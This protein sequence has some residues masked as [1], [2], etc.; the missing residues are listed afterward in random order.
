MQ[1]DRGYLSPYFI[2]NQQNMT[3]ELESPMILLH[4]KKISNVRD[5]LPISKGVA[6]SGRSLLLVSETS[7]RGARHAR[8]QHDPRDREGLRREGAGLR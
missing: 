5:M 4:D 8:R 7:R 2:N 6:K 1:F 3:T